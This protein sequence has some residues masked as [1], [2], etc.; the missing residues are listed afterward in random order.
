MQAKKEN[1][2]KKKKASDIATLESAA[3]AVIAHNAELSAHMKRGVT[4][5]MASPPASELLK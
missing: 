4:A 3:R 1:E 5:F 2:K